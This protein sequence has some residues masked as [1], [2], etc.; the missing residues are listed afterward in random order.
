MDQDITAEPTSNPFNFAHP[1]IRS[2]ESAVASFA[3]ELLALCEKYRITD[4]SGTAVVA[5][6]AQS[7]DENMLFVKTFNVDV[8]AK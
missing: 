1:D 6:H 3:N 8:I 7:G 5:A 2:A 4:F